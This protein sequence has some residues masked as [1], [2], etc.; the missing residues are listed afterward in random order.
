MAQKKHRRSAAPT[1]WDP[2]A[3]WYAGWAGASGSEHHR[4]LAIPVVLEL[5][6]PTAGEQILDIGAGVGVLAPL[7]AG[8]GAHYTGVDASA[9]LIAF[10][11]RHHGA[12]GRFLHGDAT[13]LAALPELRASSF[14]GAVFLLSIQDMDPLDA[15]LTSAA[16]ALLPG[17]RVVLLM[18]HPC[19]RVPRQTGW[20]WD[21]ERKLQYRRVD[22]YLTPLA[23]PMKTYE[24]PHPG[25][26]RSF[27]RPLEAYVNG[28]AACGL[29]VDC[30]REV[31]TYKVRP[32]GPRAS[33]EN[34]ANGEIPLFLGL[35]AWK[36]L[37]T[38]RE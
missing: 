18:T 5:L 4:R 34:R 36:R 9:K 30:V 33:A 20:G 25:A 28:L 35:R 23:V 32:A 22:R 2:V 16:W 1:S 11:R 13:R 12:D 38:I 3:D 37:K 21:E 10:A 19:F 17:G 6:A 26:T 29:L 15:V 7:V 8:A 14:D 31:P 24:T 27:H